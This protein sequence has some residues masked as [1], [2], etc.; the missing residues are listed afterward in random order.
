VIF[1]N[2]HTDSDTFAELSGWTIKPVGACKGDACVPLPTA[3]RA[4]DGTL[5]LRVVTERLGMGLVED[6]GR[7]LYAIGPES[8]SGQSLTSAVAPELVLPD[9]EGREFRLSSL[10]GQKVL[11]VAWAS[12]CGCRADLPRWQDQRAKLH[13]RG[14]EIVTVALDVEGA[15]AARPWIE[16]ARPEHPALIDREHKLGELFGVL[17]VP[18]GIWIDED[19]MIVRPPEQVWP[20]ATEV[21][22]IDDADLPPA[23]AE[24]LVEVRKIPFATERSMTMIEDWVDRGHDSQFAL[25]PGQVVEKAAPRGLNTSRA[26]AHFELGQWLHRHGDHPGA[27]EHW[28][29]AHRLQPENWTYKRQAWDIED[30]GLQ[31]PTEAYEGDW[32]TDIRKVG[33]DNYYRNL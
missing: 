14:L 22:D 5:D 11:I 17:N 6:T 10:R 31:G 20:G 1:D 16:R 4:E 33:A 21:D 30:P 15:Q 19:G 24:M 18:N 12:W 3:S 26:A 8:L 23:A 9:I 25:S 2:L 27:V 7:G 13:P 32:L 29:A 28:R